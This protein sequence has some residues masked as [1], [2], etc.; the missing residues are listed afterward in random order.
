M[1]HLHAV[2]V[3]EKLLASGV[4]MFAGGGREYWS[5]HSLPDGAHFIRVDVDGRDGGDGRSLLAEAWRS[6]PDEGGRIERLD[7]RAYGRHGDHIRQ[8]RARFVC[9]PD[10]VEAGISLNGGDRTP[11]Q[12][13]LSQ[14]WLL[15]GGTAFFLGDLIGQARL[16]PWQEVSTFSYNLHFDDNKAF[17]GRVYTGRMEP[18]EA[19]SVSVDGREIAGHTY[20]WHGPAG[21]Y[22]LQVNAYG[23]LL[24]AVRDDGWS[25]R[26]TRYAQSG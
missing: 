21:V 11:Q 6:P 25:A 3:H 7:L 18:G 8:A 24:A 12:T 19:A 4:Y 26:L 9:L 16:L 10:G 13:A 5:V 23:I 2:A 15:D 1:R 17:Y 14:P 22:T 20:R